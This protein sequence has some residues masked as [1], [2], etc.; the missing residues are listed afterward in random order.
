MAVGGDQVTKSEIRRIPD[1]QNLAGHL[2]KGK[3]WHQ[4]E[5]LI[6]G[7]GGT[8]KM[9]GDTKGSNE[10]RSGKGDEKSWGCVHREGCISAVTA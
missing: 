5:T 9:N 10:Q 7:V 2:T 6:R 1:K 8:M 3:A 4:I